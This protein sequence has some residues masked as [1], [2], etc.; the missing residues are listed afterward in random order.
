MPTRLRGSARTVACAHRH[1]VYVGQ[2]TRYAN[3]FLPGDPS[4]STLGQPMTAV[5]SVDLF[6]TMLRGPIGR[7]YAARFKT[8][9]RGLDLV[10]TCPLDMPC[11]A[12]V[13]LYVA[14]GS[15]NRRDARSTCSLEGPVQ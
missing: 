2:G 1:G 14:N 6:A 13:L 9:L 12:D 7:R 3:P 15:D 11:H 4:P 8:V 10:C 5:E